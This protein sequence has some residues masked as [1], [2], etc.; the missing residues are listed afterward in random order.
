M[1]KVERHA[2]SGRKIVETAK[3]A[4]KHKNRKRKPKQH[5]NMSCHE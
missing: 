4:S 1:P 5:V 2:N 3:E